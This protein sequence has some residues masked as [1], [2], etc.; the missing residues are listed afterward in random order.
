MWL[1][2]CE[3]GKHGHEFFSDHILLLRSKHRARR[4]MSL[5]RDKV[6]HSSD[7]GGAGT[8]VMGLF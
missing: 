7:R 4:E 5:N 3:A 1:E 8:E 2:I 6:Y